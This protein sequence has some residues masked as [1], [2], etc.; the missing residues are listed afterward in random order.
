MNIDTIE[1]LVDLGNLPFHIGLANSP[2]N[3]D[4]PDTLPFVVGVQADIGLLV[5]APNRTVQHYLEQAY[6]KGSIIGTPMDSDGFGR[7]YA[8]DFLTYMARVLDFNAMDG[9]RVL[10]IGCGNGYLLHRLKELG[11]RVLGIEPGESGQVGAQQ[12]GIEI[13]RG[14]FPSERLGP[15]DRFDV[16]IHYG[17]LEHVTDP[18]SFLAT[19]SQYLSDSGVIF[20]AVPDCREYIRMSDVS[21]F[22]HEHWSYFSPSPLKALV[23]AVGLRLLNLEKSGFGGGLYA[24]A[25]GSGISTSIE[26]DPNEIT[27]FQSRVR[28]NIERAKTFFEQAHERSIGV[29][30]PGRIINLLKLIQPGKLPR[31]F[32]DD[33]NIHG[34]YFPPFDVSVESRAA[35][36]AD[37]VDELVIMSR[38]FGSKLRTELLQEDASKAIHIVLP[39]ELFGTE[40]RA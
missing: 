31:F 26:S 17:V 18:R 12:Y 9:L 1:Q 7:Q 40:G 4:L 8:D 37:P 5:Q 25:S 22:I 10:E 23:E 16:I 19:Q 29:F 32:D 36:L 6:Y 39:D 27:F 38:S 33:P 35:L 14:M 34:K 11:A 28:E 13:V 2:S 20:F 15:T 30:C 3:G 21:M 24:T